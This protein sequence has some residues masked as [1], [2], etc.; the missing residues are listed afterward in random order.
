ML[1]NLILS[2]DPSWLASDLDKESTS[3]SKRVFNTEDGNLI[4]KIFQHMIKG[5][6]TIRR[7][8]VD[9]IVDD[10]AENLLESYTRE[11]IL[12]RVRTEKRA[13]DRREKRKYR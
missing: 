5:K 3:T 6:A 12:L 4:R 7:S 10:K 8:E 13:Y 11:Q 2:Q 9:A 1:S